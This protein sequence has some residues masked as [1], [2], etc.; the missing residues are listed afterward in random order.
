MGKKKEEGKRRRRMR[1]VIYIYN[2][3]AS[4]FLICVDSTFILLELLRS[5]LP[6]SGALAR[7]QHFTIF[8]R[9]FF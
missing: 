5:L 6:F 3:D 8:L 9:L 4:F 7:N 2:S 1:G